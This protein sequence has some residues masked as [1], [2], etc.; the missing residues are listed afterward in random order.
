MGHPLSAA[1]AIQ[2]LHGKFFKGVS[3]KAH[4]GKGSIVQQLNNAVQPYLDYY[5]PLYP[6]YPNHYEQHQ[7]DREE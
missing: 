1:N 6:M 7:H 3:L 2:G 5:E 4:W